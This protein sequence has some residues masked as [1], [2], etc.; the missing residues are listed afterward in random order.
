MDL[1][2]DNFGINPVLHFQRIKKFV[3]IYQ[4]YQKTLS[5]G[6]ID[7]VLANF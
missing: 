2:F 7:P 1:N 6:K 3:K 4:K 5:F